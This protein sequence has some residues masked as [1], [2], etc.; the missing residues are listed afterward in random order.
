MK[1]RILSA[2]LTLVMLFS[3]ASVSFAGEADHWVSA[4]STSPI[5]ASLSELGLLNN[6]GV[7]L[8]SVS[9]RV[10]ITP[11]VSGDAVRLHFS[12]EYG[13]TPLH[14]SACSVAK[15]D[16]NNRNIVCKGK[17]AVTFGGKTCYTI[18]AGKTVVSDPINFPVCAMSKISVTTYFRSFN[19]QRTV[20]LIGGRTYAVVGN[21]T[22][23]PSMHLG[24]PLEYSASSGTYQV[25]PALMGV[26]VLSRD[27]SAANCVIFGDSTVANEIPRL[28]AEKLLDAGITNVSVTQQAIKG[29]RLLQNGVGIGAKLLGESGL[30][31]FERDVLDQP[32]VKY[33]IVKLGVNDIVHPFCKSKASRLV[34]VTVEEMT[35]AYAAL[36]EMAHE[37]GI[38]IYFAELTPW[39]GYT[40]DIFGTG[41]DVQWTE[42]IDALRLG[43]N[44]WLASNECKADGYIPLTS[45]A[46]PADPAALLP[47]YTTDGAH[48]TTA[49]QQAVVDCIATDLFVG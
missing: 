5:N 47:A 26:D 45:L 34:P 40:R 39:K 10:V 12:N 19:T 1:K 42:E 6:L 27:S 18:P 7:T 20:G 11:T 24:V 46:D 29:N 37:K 16:S 30:D 22:N 35:N 8:L 25:I 38:A 13:L 44:A 32:G 14:I 49:G 33:V 15:T 3:L 17:K 2:L 4:W 36:V 41:D 21:Y 9:S 43:V 28:L 31:R 23:T 48:L